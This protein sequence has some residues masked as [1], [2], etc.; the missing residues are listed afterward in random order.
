M[1]PPTVQSGRC[2]GFT[3]TVKAAGE[4]TIGILAAFRFY[5]IEAVNCRFWVESIRKLQTTL[6]LVEEKTAGKAI[7]SRLTSLGCCGMIGGRETASTIS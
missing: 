3:Q 1:D 7:F 4:T 6:E 5:R 2:S